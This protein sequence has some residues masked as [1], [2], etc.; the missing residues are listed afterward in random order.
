[1]SKNLHPWTGIGKILHKGSQRFTNEIINDLT[2]DTNKL[3]KSI[4]DLEKRVSSTEEKF[5][6]VV[7]IS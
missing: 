6:M 3:M 2:E 5:K 4:N 7:E 1:M